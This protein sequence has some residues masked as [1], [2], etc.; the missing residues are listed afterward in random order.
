MDRA[1]SRPANANAAA[2]NHDEHRQAFNLGYA[3]AGQ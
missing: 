1:A 2:T 3:F